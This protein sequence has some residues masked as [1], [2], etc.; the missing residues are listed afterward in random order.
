MK[1]M[2]KQTGGSEKTPVLLLEKKRSF[3]YVTVY[4]TVL[5]N[6]LFFSRKAEQFSINYLSLCLSEPVQVRQKHNEQQKSKSE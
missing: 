6:K 4:G 1:G 3:S 5:T 2:P